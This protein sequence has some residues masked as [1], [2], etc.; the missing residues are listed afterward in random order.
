MVELNGALS[1]P[2]VELE[3]QDTMKLASG[4]VARSAL[5]EASTP[6]KPR[7]GATYQAVFDVLSEAQSAMRAKEIHLAC[8]LR[9]GQPVVWGT[10]KQCLSVNS[11]GSTSKYLRVGHGRYI[12]RPHL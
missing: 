9:L 5:R 6:V 8:Q 2:R 12:L 7:Q 1:N 3:I 11:Q 10:V 4:L